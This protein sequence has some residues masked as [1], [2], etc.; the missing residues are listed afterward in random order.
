MTLLL[1]CIH[2]NNTQDAGQY[3]TNTPLRVMMVRMIL[4]FGSY[5]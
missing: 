2:D 3:L 4:K 5:V 1:N